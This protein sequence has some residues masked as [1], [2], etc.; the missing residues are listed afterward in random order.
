MPPART[1]ESVA[2]SHQMRRCERVFEVV[3][4]EVM[5]FSL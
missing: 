4:V 2:K 1:I 5:G 3:S